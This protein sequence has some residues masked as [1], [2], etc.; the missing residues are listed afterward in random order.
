MPKSVRQTVFWNLQTPLVR[1][2]VDRKKSG[3]HGCTPEIKRVTYSFLVQSL[4]FDIGL[5]LVLGCHSSLPW[6]ASRMTWVRILLRDLLLL[7]P[8]LLGS[9]QEAVPVK[10]TGSVME[11]I[12]F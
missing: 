7:V 2:P 8:D 4:L 9:N 6:P 1:S 3:H 5:R 11:E 10:I 12:K